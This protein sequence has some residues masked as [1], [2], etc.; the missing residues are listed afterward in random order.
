MTGFSNPLR[1]GQGDDRPLI[2]LPKPKL[3]DGMSLAEALAKRRSHRSFDAKAPSLEQ[4]SQICWAAQGITDSE[5]GFRTAP[6][7]GALY[8]VTVVLIDTNGVSE[9][10]PG[11]HALRR[12][13][14]GDVRERLHG[15]ALRQTPVRSAPL[16][17][18]VAIDIA[19][20]AGKYGERAERYCLLE[21]GHVAQNVLLQATAVGLAGVPIGA[22]DDHQVAAV[23]ELPG[24]L[25]P[26][27]LIP[28]GY[29]GGP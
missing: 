16:C 7:A 6:S 8:P 11:P 21:A 14:S 26:V 27:Y 15:S 22:F 13:V 12:T 29:P 1:A 10:L 28:L 2:Q 25:R 24:R 18:V 20:T 4:V 19:R 17:V 9:Y 3:K 5:R 23:L